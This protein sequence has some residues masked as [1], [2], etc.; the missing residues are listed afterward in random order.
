[1]YLGN[2]VYALKDSKNII[3]NNPQLTMI[4]SFGKLYK[5]QSMTTDV[6]SPNIIKSPYESNLVT[7]ILN[8]NKIIASSKDEPL[9]IIKTED[10]IDKQTI[11]VSQDIEII[12]DEQEIQED[13]QEIDLIEEDMS[14]IEEDMTIIEEDTNVIEED[15]NIIEEDTNV[16]EEDTN[17]IEEDT[18]VIEE[19]TSIIE[20]DNR[21]LSN[22][23]N[24]P[25]ELNQI[26]EQI[27]KSDIIKPSPE[28][29]SLENIL[30]DFNKLFNISDTKEVFQKKDSEIIK[31]KH[32]HYLKIYK[33]KNKIYQKHKKK[34]N[35]K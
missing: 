29:F 17:V 18:N 35:L 6:P 12:K 31:K 5:Q 4:T 14:I 27:I 22:V 20:E 2:P 1:L 8:K 11:K 30:S 34:K 23:L 28:L 9:N 25:I 13:S 19:D 21:Q 7:D 33:L 3:I 15:T 26:K 10:V 24:I 32:K 16:I